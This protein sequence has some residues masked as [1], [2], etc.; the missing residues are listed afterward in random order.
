M[1]LVG[2]ALA[3]LRADAAEHGW[4]AA[5]GNVVRLATRRVLYRRIVEVSIYCD[6]DR[7]GDFR[8]APDIELSEATAS[9]LDELV[10]FAR[11]HVDEADAEKLRGYMRNGYCGQLARIGGVLAGYVWSVDGTIPADRTHPALHRFDFHLKPG[12]TYSWDLYLAPDFRGGGR[13]RAF[14]GRSMAALRDKGYRRMYGWVAADNTPARLLYQ[15]LGWQDIS[16]RAS[17]LLFG[18]VLVTG[19]RVFVANGLDHQTPYDYRPLF[20]R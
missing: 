14:Y 3:R 7:M 11:T 19:R 15:K 20:G 5:A 1:S 17:V 4:A 13:A 9:D 8:P 18:R 6:L 10:Q 16:E 12:E 2:R